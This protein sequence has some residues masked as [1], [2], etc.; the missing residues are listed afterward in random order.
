MRFAPLACCASLAASVASAFTPLETIR[1]ATV[2]DTTG[3][4][5]SALATPSASSSSSSSSSRQEDKSAEEITL[6]CLDV[7][8]DLLTRFGSVSISITRQH[9]QILHIALSQLASI[10]PVV[11]KRAGNAIGCLAAV[12]SDTL[13]E[14]LVES[15]L[16]QI[17]LAE[18]VGRSG[19]RRTRAAHRAESGGGKGSVPDLKVADTRALIRTMCTVSG[20]V[21]H[22]LGQRQ[23]DRIVPIFLRF[24]DPEDAASGDDEDMDD[25][26]E[27]DDAGD[28]GGAQP[29]EAAMSL[30]NELR[31]SCFAGFESFILRCPN[32][33][34]PH[35]SLIIHAALSYMRY[36][37]NYS[38]GDDD[39]EDGDSEGDGGEE[40]EEEEDEYSDEEEDEYSDEEDDFSDD[41]DDSWKVRRS[42]IRTLSAVVR[43]TEHDPS[44]LWIDEYAWRRNRT[45]GVTVAGA[46]VNRFKEREENCRVDVV[47]CFTRLL[48]TTVAAS[49]T[50]VLTLAS[51]TA[52]DAMDTAS[53]EAAGGGG[54]GGPVVIDL[55]TKF[56]PAIVK[57]CEKQLG[58]KRGG[59]RT[60]SSALALLSTLCNAPGGVG[61]ADQI[62]SVF[63]H[64]KTILGGSGGDGRA[65]SRS[66]S[67]GSKSLK[68]DALCLVR[69]TLA[70][71]NH[72]PSDVRDALLDVLLL[73]LCASVNEDWYK[74]IAEALRVLSEVPRLLVAARSSK[75]SSAEDVK[76]EM[77]RVAGALY[78]AIEPR[79][80]AHDL[81]QEI[82]ECALAASASLLSLLHGSLSAERQGRLLALLLDRLKNETT[83]IAAIKTLSVIGAASQGETE[84]KEG[85]G[86]L[87]LSPILADA[88]LELASL[89]RQQSRGIK[90]SA[91]EALVIVVRC[92]GSAVMD[93]A[94]F[95]SVL[96][97]LGAIIV[98][99]DLHISHLSLRASMS[100]L[101]VCPASGPSVKAHVLP[102]ALVLSTSPLLQDLALDSLLSL[103][104]QLVLSDAVDFA[105]LLSSLR[106]RLSAGDEKGGRSSAASA[107]A[108]S[109]AASAAAHGGSKQAV[110][111]LAKCVATIA[112]ATTPENREAVVA[113]L[114]STL[115]S[116][117]ATAGEGNAQRIQLALLTS[118]D[119]GR[120][121]DLSAT[122]GT[123]DRLQRIYV[124]SFDSSSDDVRHA[125]A[126]AL[127][128]A[129]VGAM[130]VFLP[131]ILN[132]LEEN[133]EKKQYLLLSALRELIHC[134]QIEGEGGGGEAAGDGVSSSVPLIL[135]HLFKHC[136]DKEEGVRTMVAE[137][138]GSL[139]CLQPDVILPQ[140]RDLVQ[141]HSGKPAA[142][143][144]EEGESEE[145][146]KDALVCWTVA[147]SV[148]FAIAGKADPAQ[149]SPFMPSFLV[150]LQEDD[151]SVKNTALLMVYSA[152]HHSPHLV[153]GLMQEHILP[154]LYEV[155]I[156]N[157]KRVVDLGPF[158]HTVD[159]AIP[160]R[161]AALSI[162][163]TCLEKCP[164]CL[165]V[166]AFM[167]ILAKA[168]A[169]VED[170]Q[171]QAHQIVISMCVRHPVPIAA[172]VETFVEPL[173]KTCNKKKGQKTGTELERVNEWIKSGLRVM[174]SLSRVDGVMDCRKFADFVERTRKMQKFHPMLEAL[175]EER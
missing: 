12:I 55:R 125:A 85:G 166:P 164:G 123:A 95:D 172:A 128:R 108:P 117:S 153:A 133:R 34:E 67:V 156:L 62:R 169:D 86:G 146:R 137:C 9:E 56:V 124:S 77:D 88:V 73:D 144:E 87:D 170:V 148:K 26:E 110:T 28:G 10:R 168:L 32:E 136:G 3:A 59:E 116:G 154:S 93:A 52:A 84:E 103:L 7:L 97:E 149:L 173:E 107:G 90:Q 54:G 24:C 106:G 140:L 135:P 119:L 43:A 91:L 47:D 35:L 174:V 171:L 81:D 53:D 83:R 61:G 141:K 4:E 65:L 126:Y 143:L 31:E 64:V 89:L 111:N 113:D 1:S 33:I 165:D 75:S 29:D 18:G 152:V 69:V 104:R 57:A 45:K 99:S 98:D 60:K 158:K 118:G 14:R 134:H 160:L 50:G 82:K 175:D 162:F 122:E 155:A 23:I 139:T 17:D 145:T 11:R 101:Q 70:C 157:L 46:L 100:V 115:E 96:K 38:Y 40:E 6:S 20:A 74:V 127:G 19:K 132:A 79:L 39:D 66:V 112:A 42:A 25:D 58:A 147:I 15:L 37:P 78:E 120:M 130:P 151:L 92:Q 105:D 68:L 71:G 16:S 114:L 41:D 13:L 72:D 102:S 150:L 51:T 80:A 142:Q 129:S 138:L 22:R 161:K 44:K 8:T 159:D 21:G 76:A 5:T 30:A 94:M 36:D 131:A 63:V 2:L 121:V 109:A 49:A 167:P 27:M 48:S 163:S